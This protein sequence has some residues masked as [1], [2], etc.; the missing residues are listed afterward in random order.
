MKLIDID[1]YKRVSDKLPKLF[2]IFQIVHDYSNS[3]EVD[4]V[5]FQRR[6]GLIA[7]N[8]SPRTQ[9]MW[10]AVLDAKLKTTKKQGILYER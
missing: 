9:Q 1:Y 10:Q 6:L 2:E 3:N 4:S 5:E 8:S 7:S